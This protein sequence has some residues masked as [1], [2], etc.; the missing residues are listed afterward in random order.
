MEDRP[1]Q[2]HRQ[3]KDILPLTME[4][5]VADSRQDRESNDSE[6]SLRS[7]VS[8]DDDSLLLNDSLDDFDDNDSN[9]S[10]TLP[11]QHSGSSP[12]RHRRFSSHPSISTEMAIIASSSPEIKALSSQPITPSFPRELN[13]DFYQQEND[14]EVETLKV[15]TT[16]TSPLP[17]TN[18]DH[19]YHKNSEQ[20][21]KRTTRE[22]V[23]ISTDVSSSALHPPETRMDEADELALFMERQCLVRDVS[24]PPTVIGEHKENLSPPFSFDGKTPEASNR[25]YDG[26][27]VPFRS[28]M[29]KE[30]KDHHSLISSMVGSDKRRPTFHRRVSFT[31]L[32]SP[33]EIASPR[34]QPPTP[35]DTS[36]SLSILAEA[37]PRG[38][39]PLAM[40]FPFF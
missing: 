1:H 24:S 20:A 14:T 23:C 28:A 37:P 17:A 27:S 5:L 40:D 11:H 35:L 39:S 13:F 7:L 16:M 31:S 4:I 6:C 3:P 15:R 9:A 19:T 32:P 10:P 26:S 36:N 2:D 18:T 29:R 34:V 33:A 22:D 25:S 21:R 38:K 8:G 12:T 30:T